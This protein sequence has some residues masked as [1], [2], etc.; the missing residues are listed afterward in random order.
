MKAN[1]RGDVVGG[2]ATVRKN[3]I[4]LKVDRPVW[5]GE[6]ETDDIIVCHGSGLIE[7]HPDDSF[8]VI[9]DSQFSGQIFDPNFVRAGG[10]VIGATQ[11]GL[12]ARVYWVTTN[13]VPAT[14]TVRAHTD[15]PDQLVCAVS[16]EGVAAMVTYSLGQGITL[17]RDGALIGSISTTPLGDDAIN[18]KRVRVR[19][20][21]VFWEDTTGPHFVALDTLQ[22]LP[23]VA[24]PDQTDV[25]E[26]CPG[27]RPL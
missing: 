1:G 11:I 23:F 6:F 9:D 13:Q 26:M 25:D 17:Y 19:G 20:N 7:Y 15:Y 3:A 14:P 18:G 24:R 27:L 12:P 4:P 10:G 21:V 16:P 2:S 22:P 8:S 5:Q